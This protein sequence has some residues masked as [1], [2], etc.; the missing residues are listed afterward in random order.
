M[1]KVFFL[2]MNVLFSDYEDIQIDGQC[3]K[4]IKW[5]ITLRTESN[6]NNGTK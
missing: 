1:L 2:Q 4:E 5:N 3:V 6:L